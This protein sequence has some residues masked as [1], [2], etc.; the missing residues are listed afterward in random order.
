LKK[1]L[2]LGGGHAH[3]H[4]LKS[5]IDKSLS[6][7][8]ITLV[9]PYARQVYSGMLPGW[10]AGHYTINDCVIPLP[11]LAKKA[12]VIFH[13]AAADE[14]DLKRSIVRCTDGSEI[15]FDVLSIDAGPVANLDTIP[16]AKDNAIAIRPI[17]SFI[18]SIAEIRREVDA[19]RNTHI[20]F[21]GAGAGGVELA[22]AMRHTFGNRADI[23]LISAENTLPGKVGERLVRHLQARGVRLLANEAAARVAPG[24]V[25]LE[26][27]LVINADIII[28]ATGTAA[29]KWPR[30]AGL[31]TDARGF[32][33]VN[34]FLQSTSHPHVFA[35]G[36]CATMINFSRP[37]SGVYAV[38]AGPPLAE[39]LRRFI[40]S[41]SLKCYTPQ[42]RSL[43][44]VSTGDKYAIASW[45]NIAIEGKWVW[46]WKDKI[47]RG[48]MAKYALEELK[49]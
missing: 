3:V 20:A 45:G 34:D 1:L 32:I 22:L 38:R 49:T 8:E 2:L 28:I 48:F 5:L 18:E 16:G 11:P 25:L 42:K 30:D 43:Y 44:L 6:D 37:K 15:S 29:A 21:I 23:T 12:G 26:S 46:R 7:A 4:V 31:A 39:N 47:D 27:A 14:I 10:V 41:E 35:A 40:H 17:E 24:A 36:D 13:Q 33:A 19:R 9:S